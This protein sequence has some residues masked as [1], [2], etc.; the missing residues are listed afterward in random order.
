M[1][2]RLHK[3]L[4]QA[5]IASRRASERLIR[6]GRVQVNGRVVTGMGIQVDPDS[7]AIRV[8]G[9]RIRPAAAAAAYWA[10]HKPRGVVTTLSDPE[11]RPT[12]KDLLPR[13]RSRLFPVGRLDYDSE[14]LLLL[15]N[16]GSLARSLMHPS[17]GVV[18]TY[19]VKV[20]GRP[21]GDTLRRLREGV[22]VGGRKT[23]PAQARVARDGANPWLEI[24]IV[25]GRNRQVRR[26]LDAVGHPVQRLRRTGYGGVLLGGLR[27]GESRPLTEAEIDRLRSAVRDG[28]RGPRAK[29]AHHP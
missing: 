15:T 8:D 19:W 12:V 13:V 21:D 10:L 3:V 27:A 24:R 20:R 6:E 29:P 28:T 25:E 1:T 11:G 14:G 17:S 7:D 22:W 5:G 16:D 9:K 18:K 23:L 2:E 26:M 4:S